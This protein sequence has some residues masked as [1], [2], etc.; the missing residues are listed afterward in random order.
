MSHDTES[1]LRTPICG[2]QVKQVQ[3]QRLQ[4]EHL[5]P[6]LSFE[7]PEDQHRFTALP[8]E[9]LEISLR[10]PERHPIV[11]T[12]DEEVV[13]FFVLH[14]GSGV[15]TYLSYTSTSAEQLMLLRALLIDHKQ[16]GHGYARRAME[17]LQPFVQQHFP[18]IHEIV[19]AVNVRNEPAQQ[20]YLRTGFEDHGFRRPGAIGMQWMMHLMI[21]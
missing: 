12:A 21:Q 13:G 3:L 18:H 1:N 20:L 17:A 10:D 15:S 8:I 11:I 16:Q 7:L 4:P 9:V 14:E 5:E 19:L 2:E 6:L